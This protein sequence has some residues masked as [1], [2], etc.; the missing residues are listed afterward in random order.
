[1]DAQT[2][3]KSQLKLKIEPRGTMRENT[4]MN[5]NT[6]F[7]P[8][9]SA[10]EMLS[11]LSSAKRFGSH[12]L[13]HQVG[14]RLD[15]KPMDKDR[16]NGVGAEELELPLNRVLQDLCRAAIASNGVAHREA[17]VSLQTHVRNAFGCV[18]K[19]S[20]RYSLKPKPI[21]PTKAYSAGEAMNVSEFNADV[22]RG[23]YIGVLF[24]QLEDISDKTDTSL[25]MLEGSTSAEE[26]TP[27]DAG[28]PL[29]TLDAEEPRP[30]ETREITVVSNDVLLAEKTADALVG[31]TDAIQRAERSEQLNKALTK[32][33]RSFRADQ[34]ELAKLRA[35]Q[36]KREAAAAKRRQTRKAKA[37][38][39]TA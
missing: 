32:K 1:M 11:I 25:V 34:R 13:R 7:D 8:S 2:Q 4:A 39:K 26:K 9:V 27:E 28:E 21:M 36:A 20:T 12:W 38:A 6:N 10:A 37:K 23:A 33:L 22:A 3:A 18:D 30:I 15:G 24:K 29:P 35:E 17:F 16:A 5:T 31:L 14:Q 19:C